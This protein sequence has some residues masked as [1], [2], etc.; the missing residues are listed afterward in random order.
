[1]P[2]HT[3]PTH[4]IVDET[5][6]NSVNYSRAHA[7]ACVCVST[8]TPSN[9][10]NQ[11]I[12][13]AKCYPFCIL[14]LLLVFLFDSSDSLPI[15]SFNYFTK[16]TI[17]HWIVSMRLLEANTFRE[18]SHTRPSHT[19]THIQVYF[20]IRFQIFDTLA[21]IHHV[22][23]VYNPVESKLLMKHTRTGSAKRHANRIACRMF[24][25]CSFHRRWL[26]AYW[27]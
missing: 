6:S 27:C 22:L 19:H 2:A 14:C 26:C 23:Y 10:P 15:Y 1:M 9:Q 17:P 16:R 12:C 21:H 11:P 20:G 8:V 5:E 18:C 3:P 4:I 25:S 24:I 13:T 7:P